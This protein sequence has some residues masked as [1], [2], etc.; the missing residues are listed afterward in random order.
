MRLNELVEGVGPHPDVGICDP[1]QLPVAEGFELSQLMDFWIMGKRMARDDDVGWNMGVF[2]PQA[3]DDRCASILRGI[4]GEQDFVEGVIQMEER[5]EVPFHVI[6]DIPEGLEDAHQ[7]VFL[8]RLPWFVLSPMKQDSQN[9]IEGQNRKGKS[10][11]TGHEQCVHAP[12]LAEK[13]KFLM[14]E[15]SRLC[16]FGAAAR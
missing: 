13:R 9:R 4:H 5:F 3:A 1:K 2:E 12:S 11:K 10:Q 7:R 6:V 16:K 8:K 14:K 15:S